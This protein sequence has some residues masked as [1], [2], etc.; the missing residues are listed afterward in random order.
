MSNS[1][2]SPGEY[3]RI[4]QSFTG[5][6]E[7]LATSGLALLIARKTGLANVHGCGAY[8]GPAMGVNYTVREVPALIKDW[9]CGN[10]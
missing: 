5:L 3:K 9:I 8:A 10:L 4:L 1:M 2:L 6:T 7:P